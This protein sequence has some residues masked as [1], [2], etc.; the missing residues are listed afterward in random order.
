MSQHKH[1]PETA[2]AVAGGVGDASN[3]AQENRAQPEE[4]ADSATTAQLQAEIEQ[5]RQQVEENRNLFLQARADVENIRK[6][7]ERDLQNAHK[8]ALDK[9]VAELL[10]VKDSLEMGLAAIDE[11]A[12]IS[13]LR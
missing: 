1:A 12:D 9:F 11:S 8:Y 3:P 6:R 13:K 5:L 7:A 2:E 10:P 4:S